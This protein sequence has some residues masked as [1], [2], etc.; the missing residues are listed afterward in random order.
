LALRVLSTQALAA[1][2]NPGMQE[3]SFGQQTEVVQ[4]NPLA[5]AAGTAAT[6]AAITGANPA[7]TAIVGECSQLPPSAQVSHPERLIVMLYGPPTA[8]TTTQAA[9]LNSRYGLPVVTIDGLLQVS[10]TSMLNAKRDKFM[11]S[12]SSKKSA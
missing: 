4:P 7:E 8:P 11:L 9:L 6:T 5:E 1:A 2:Q 10:M 3:D 12:T